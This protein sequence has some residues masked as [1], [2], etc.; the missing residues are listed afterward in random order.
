MKFSGRSKDEL[1]RFNNDYS[2][3][4]SIDDSLTDSDQMMVVGDDSLLKIAVS[5]LIDNACKYSA[6]HS[7][8]IKFRHIEK[9]I[10]I[11]FEDKGIGIAQKMILKKYLNHF[12]VEQILYPFQVPELAFPLSVR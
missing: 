1:I 9:F 8:D 6:D 10:E 5:N 3:N 4:I 2:I 11:D 12:T 7:V